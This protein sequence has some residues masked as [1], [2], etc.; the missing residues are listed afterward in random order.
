MTQFNNITMEEFSDPFQYIQNI[1]PSEWPNIPKPLLFAVASIKQCLMTN[2]SKISEINKKM[3]TNDNVL[4]KKFESIDERSEFMNT[5]VITIDETLKSSIKENT[6]NL[7]SEM[8]NFKQMLTKDIDFKQKSNDT[9]LNTVQDQLFS[10]KKTLTAMP[11]MKEVE[12]LIADSCEALRKGL[13]YDVIE[14]IVNPEVN[15]ITKKIASVI[16][17]QEKYI[18]KFQELF[19]V[20]R[21]NIQVLEKQTAEKF[22]NFERLFRISDMNKDNELD[23]INKA[24]TKIET[25]L[26]ENEWQAIEKNKITLNNIANVEKNCKEIEAKNLKAINE[27]KALKENFTN[28]V[29]QVNQ[30]IQE[31]EENR[32]NELKMKKELDKKRNKSR[33]QTE[34][35]S[36]E[37]LQDRARKASV[38]RE[39][40]KELNIEE[41]VEKQIPEVQA[42]E[43]EKETEKVKEMQAEVEIQKSPN[44]LE[45]IIETPQIINSNTKG[46]SSRSNISQEHIYLEESYTVEM[47][48]LAEKFKVFQDSM[49]PIYNSLKSDKV[50]LDLLIKELKE[51]LSWLPMNLNHIKDKSPNEAR[52]Y[53]LE[54]RLRM[55]ENSRVEQFNKLL[56]LIFQSKSDVQAT[57][58]LAA[59]QNFP[60][61]SGRLT[62]RY[63]ERR[64]SIEPSINID[65][66]KRS[67]DTEKRIPI[68][69]NYIKQDK[70]KGSIRKFSIDVDRINKANHY[71]KRSTINEAFNF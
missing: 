33:K 47:N 37:K 52:I 10:I 23:A 69:N 22:I 55:E 18:A 4:K 16:E 26:K 63:P 71:I 7:Y 9:K 60:Q 62:A 21:N 35:K 30:K 17:N 19:E 2:S 34:V 14:N 61:V 54:T 42:K 56:S 8:F 41:E 49:I 12:K 3:I 40:T 11:F 67:A 70:I 32:L 27:L 66:Q 24:I 6:E 1:N 46:I 48:A 65:Q 20:F 15:D 59:N 5:M 28:Y 50:E 57:G 13:R 39:D 29:N 36:Y 38:G 31:D 68:D 43:K 25:A 45:I 51:K 53:T 58:L 64:P 44:R